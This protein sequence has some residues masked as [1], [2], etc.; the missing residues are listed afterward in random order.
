MPKVAKNHTVRQ[1][2]YNGTY[3]Y[4]SGKDERGTH[5]SWKDYPNRA[6]MLTM[7]QSIELYKR[8]INNCSPD[9]K[10]TFQRCKVEDRDIRE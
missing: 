7:K 5:Y 1:V 6:G 8:I 2:M 9:R 4:Y 3:V 10:W